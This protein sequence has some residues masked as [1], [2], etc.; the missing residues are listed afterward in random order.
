MA[1]R[2]RSCGDVTLFCISVLLSFLFLLPGLRCGF[3]A[4]RLRKANSDGNTLRM[5][6]ETV[7]TYRFS[8]VDGKPILALRAGC[9]R[10][11]ELR[12]AVWLSSAGAREVG[13]TSGR[14]ALSRGL[15]VK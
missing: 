15:P 4:V 12:S 2:W 6:S 8:S 5:A 3:F 13:G 10:D 7:P 11:R 1:P 14:C 9:S